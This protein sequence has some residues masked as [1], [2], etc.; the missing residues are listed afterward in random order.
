MATFDVRAAFATDARRFEAHCCSILDLPGC[1][2]LLVAN[3]LAQLQELRRGRPRRS[4]SRDPTLNP[5][6]QW[7]VDLGK[8]FARRFASPAAA[9]S[10]PVEDGSAAAPLEA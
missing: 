2:A 10:S 6:D 9:G 8:R 5:F 7:S 4:A 3:R 1:H